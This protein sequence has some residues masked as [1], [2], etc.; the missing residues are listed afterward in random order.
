M[1]HEVPLTEIKD[2]VSRYISQWPEIFLVDISI[3]TNSNKVS[4]FLDGDNGI[5]IDRCAEVN[6]ALYKFVENEEIF[7]GD[8]F[9]LEVS[10]PGIERPLKLQRQYLKNIGRTVEV[11]RT[12]MT[13]E[14]GKL[15]MADEEKLLIEKEVKPG[16]KQSEKIEM[17][18][19]FGDIKQV[20]VLVK[21]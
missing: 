21:F 11:I 10:S 17:D 13:R 18:I 16:K 15:V 14:T 6:R 20:K 7:S 2:F 9:S 3:G 4:V 5:T 8:N 12:D 19:P 1:A